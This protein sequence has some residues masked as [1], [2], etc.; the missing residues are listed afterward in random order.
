MR[1]SDVGTT[2]PRRATV[3]RR[4]TFVVALALWTAGSRPVPEAAADIGEITISAGDGLIPSARFE[5]ANRIQTSRLIATDETE[6]AAGFD[7][8]SLLLAR[9]DLYP[10]ALA[11]SLIG[12]LERAPIVLTPSDT[13]AGGLDAD[14]RQAIADSAPETITVLG[15]EQAV[16]AAV[17]DAVRAEFPGTAVERIGGQDRFETAALIADRVGSAPQAVI[18]NGGNFPDA[19]VAGPL[20]TAAG[21]PILLTNVDGAID[22]STIERLDS[23]GV[24]EVLI[25]GGEVAIAADVEAQ[26][27]ERGL[28]TRRVAGDTRVTTAIAFARLAAEEYDFGTDHVN[29]A[30]GGDFPDAL[31]LGPHAG[32]DV[33]GPAPILLTGSEEL[34]PTTQEYFDDIAGC[35]TSVHVAGGQNAISA[36]S[37]QAARAALTRAGDT[38]AV[39]LAPETATAGVGEDVTVVATVTDLT[40]SPAAPVTAAGETATVTFSI[41]AETGSAEGTATPTVTEQVTDLDADGRASVTFTSGTPGTAQIT[42]TVTDAGGTAHAATA[43]ATFEPL[44]FSAFAVVGDAQDPELLTFNVSTGE[45]L[46]RVP[47]AGLEAGERPVA[48]DIRPATDGLYV[49]GADGG[50]YTVETSG[51][52]AG[53]ASKVNDEPIGSFDRPEGV[54]GVGL[55]VDPVRDVIRVVDNLGRNLRV[56]PTDGTLVADPALSFAPDTAEGQAGLVPDVTG[57]AYGPPRQPDG[58]AA[59]YGIDRDLDALLRHVPQDS[60]TVEV[61]GELGVNPSFANGFDIVSVGGVTDVAFGTLSVGESAQV[62]LVDLETGEA[63]LVY[64]LPAELRVR[65]FTLGQPLPS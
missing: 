11:G 40:G 2:R 59:L 4:A 37:E 32:L 42:A 24:E 50:L 38:C 46:D 18:A 7:G 31:A 5:G 23:L 39:T 34:D 41:T 6:F 43:S 22:P 58:D 55:D 64:A 52:A 9:A 21:L 19:L 14:T 48:A 60:G 63:T 35:V 26:L 13:T 17:L 65:A 8:S 3:W 12:G 57:I 44:Q 1:M 28:R 45:E 36:M 25:A 62:Y 20:A 15:G 47:I 10:D 51:P 49:L 29:L 53:T 61:V 33:G 30:T 54:E 27:A 56:D 16:S